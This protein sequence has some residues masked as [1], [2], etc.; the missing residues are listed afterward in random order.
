MDVPSKTH[1]SWQDV[2]T[3]KNTFQLQFLVSCPRNECMD[4]QPVNRVARRRTTILA[5]IR[6]DKS[7]RSEREFFQGTT[8]FLRP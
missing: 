8:V 3:G 1:K 5:R 6:S 7:G 4:I 2:V